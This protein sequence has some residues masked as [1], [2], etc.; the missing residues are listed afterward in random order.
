MRCR[1]SAAVP[2][3]S[4]M[5]Q[6]PSSVL[7]RW[8]VVL[9]PGLAL[10]LAPLPGLDAGQRHLLALFAATIVALVVRPVPMGVSVLV[11]M[12]LLSLTGTLPLTTVLSGFGNGTAWLVFC[13]FLFARAVMTTGIG[14]RIAYFFIGRFGRTSLTLGYSVAISNLVLAPFVPSDTARGGGIIAP[15]IRSLAQ[16]LGSEPGPTGNRIGAYLTLVG[17]HC[18]YAASAMFLTGM[19]ANPLIAEFAHKLAGVDLT[20]GRWALAALVPGLCTFAIVPWLLHQLNPPDLQD[21]EHARAHAREKLQRMGPMRTAEKKFV[22]VMFAVIAGWITSPWHGAANSTVALAG[23]CAL[24]LAEV[25]TWNELLSDTKAWDALIWFA[26]LLMMADQLNERGVI[27]IISGAMFQH[28]HGWPWAVS[29]AVLPVSYLYAHYGFASMT[30]H[31]SALYPSFLGAA[32]AA[33]VPAPV[34]VWPL[35]FCSNLNAGLTHYGTGSAPVFF[36]PGYV[37][38]QTWWTLGFIVSAVNLAI[39]LGIGLVWWRLIG[40]W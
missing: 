36:G 14:V 21:T 27:G 3:A 23:V 7:R 37:S 6:P 4:S 26:P 12:T 8:L 2:G 5:S 34:A 35:A 25:V 16:A 19:A 15:I 13:A 30:A 22:V 24:L 40:L 17:F 31:V 38:Q 33:G 1:R 29:I 11:T 9:A 18:T 39:W 20:W 28:L 10:Y 32:L